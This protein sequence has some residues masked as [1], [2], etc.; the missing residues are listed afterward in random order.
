MNT[1]NSPY[2]GNNVQIPSASS[3]SSLAPSQP[4][5]PST[6]SSLKPASS[7][8]PTS[9]S[10]NATHLSSSISPGSLSTMQQPTA[11]LHEMDP[12]DPQSSVQQI[13]Q[14]LMMSSQLNGVSSSGNDMKT[15]NGITPTLNGG[16]CL[17]GNGISNNSAMSGTGFAGAGGIGLSVAA[18]GMRAAI[19]NS[20]MTMNG[21]VGMN[22]RSQDPTAMNHQQQDIGNRLLD[23]LGASWAQQNGVRPEE[24][25]LGIKKSFF[26]AFSIEVKLPRPRPLFFSFNTRKQQNL[27]LSLRQGDRRSSSSWLKSSHSTSIRSSAPGGRR[28]TTVLGPSS[29]EEKLLRQPQ[30]AVFSSEGRNR[31]GDAA[32]WGKGNRRRESVSTAMVGKLNSSIPRCAVYCFDHYPAEEEEEEVEGRDGRWNVSATAAMGGGTNACTC[33]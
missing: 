2:G 5:P 4:N 14:E 33:G 13:L 7:N 32:K 11:Q 28:Q 24:E 22:Y 18:S 10:H 21:R 3:S 15:I 12:N 25:A 20:A 26:N 9:T 8:N 30:A 16:N 27:T 19:A 17:V 23:K 1:A 6:F 31:R 29:K